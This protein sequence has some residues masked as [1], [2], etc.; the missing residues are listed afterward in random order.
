M[1]RA[2]ADVMQSVIF[3]AVLEAFEALRASSRGLP[4][5]MVRDIQS[6]HRNTTFDDLPKEL[7][8]A[9]GASVRTAFTQLLKEG[10]A[11]APSSGA[12]VRASVRRPDERP[13]GPRPPRG[14]GPGGARPE[15]GPGRPASGRGPQGSRPPKPGGRNG[16]K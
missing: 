7:Q 11:V 3:S 5:Q 2:A 14:Q 8:A 13:R 15:R 9:I 4:N 1:A 16:P 6:I 10:Y 12:P